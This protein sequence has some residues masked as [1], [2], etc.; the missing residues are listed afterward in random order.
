MF[1]TD[2]LAVLANRPHRHLGVPVSD[3]VL[4]TTVAGLAVQ[5][6]FQEPKRLHSTTGTDRAQRG[7]GNGDRSRTRRGG[8]SWIASAIPAGSPDAA[9]IAA[10]LTSLRLMAPAGAASASAATA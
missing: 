2:P 3:P 4:E 10:A 1:F 9:L 8:K 5:Y 6:L 7:G